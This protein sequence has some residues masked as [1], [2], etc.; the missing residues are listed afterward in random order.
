M[1]EDGHIGKVRVV[2]G[3]VRQVQRRLIACRK[4][5]P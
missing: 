4:S 1:Q 5:R 2:V 3:E